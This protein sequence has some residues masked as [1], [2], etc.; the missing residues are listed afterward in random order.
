MCGIRNDNCEHKKEESNH[1]ASP[2]IFP[3]HA[4]H[5]DCT[6]G[7]P[8]YTIT[9]DISV[10]EICRTAHKC[11]CVFGQQQNIFGGV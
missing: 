3:I 9:V 6:G 8:I 7:V 11:V 10:T 2:I 1:V 5:K 4:V